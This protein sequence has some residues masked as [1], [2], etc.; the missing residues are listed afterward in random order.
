M[1]FQLYK[2]HRHASKKNNYGR[3]NY[4][5]DC[6]FSNCICSCFVAFL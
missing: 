3:K 4:V 1:W 5:A 2:E 6:N